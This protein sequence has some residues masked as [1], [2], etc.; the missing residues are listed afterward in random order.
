MYMLTCLEDNAIIHVTLFSVFMVSP[1]VKNHCLYLVQ[2][3][4]EIKIWYIL[5]TLWENQHWQLIEL[6]SYHYSSMSF[7]RIFSKIIPEDILFFWHVF[8]INGNMEHSLHVCI[9]HFKWF[10]YFTA[11]FKSVVLDYFHIQ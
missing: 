2:N 9:L 5:K 8:T 7:Q 11:K 1:D 6:P 3:F 10:N 4:V